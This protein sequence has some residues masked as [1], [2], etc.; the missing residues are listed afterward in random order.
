MLPSNIESLIPVGPFGIDMEG[1]NTTLFKVT[2]AYTVTNG[3]EAI[4]TLTETFWCSARNEQ[5]VKEAYHRYTHENYDNNVSRRYEDVHT[6]PIGDTLEH[7]LTD[8]EAVESVSG[9][10]HIRF[11]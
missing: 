11:M 3:Q 10:K 7:K 6:H 2:V 4:G 8:I 9:L 5:Y 1:N